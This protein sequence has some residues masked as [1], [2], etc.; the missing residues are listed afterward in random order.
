MEHIDPL[1]C[2]VECRLLCLVSALSLAI[3]GAVILLLV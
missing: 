3:S 1:L 2:D